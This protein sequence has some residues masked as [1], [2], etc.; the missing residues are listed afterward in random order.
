MINASGNHYLTA[1]L[2]YAKN[3]RSAFLEHLKDFTAIPSVSTDP[4]ARSD[5]QQAAEW[6]AN[7]LRE[8]GV[9][10]VQVM[11]T[12]GHPIVYAEMLTAGS[13]APTVLIYGHYDVQPAEPLEL[14]ISPAFEATVRDE[15][16]FGRGVTDM[17]GQI[18]STIHAVE[19]ILKT[20]ALPVNI[21]F[22]IEGEEEIGSPSLPGFLKEH[23]ELLACDLAL[24]P[25]TG[26]LA[27]DLPTITYA[28]RGLAYFEIRL[29]GPDHDLHS[30]VFGGV[31]HNPGQALCELIA[32]MHDA[33][34]RITLSGFYD[35]V[36][37]LSAEEREELSRIP[38]NDSHFLDETGAPAL[39]GE[40]GYTP[41]E[42]IGARPTLEVNG[43]LSG[44]TGE[45]SKTVLPAWAMAKISMRLVPE[46][47][48]EEVHQQLLA[49]LQANVPPTIRWEV[50][51]MSGGPASLSRRDSTGVLALAKAMESVWGKRPLFKREGGSVPVVNYFRD[52]LG[53]ESVNTGFA[54]PGDNMHSPNEKMHLP[55]WYNAIDTY[56]H[57]L[58]NLVEA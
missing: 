34:G 19:A 41:I 18:M 25:D 16:I 21:K 36:L 52:Y 39:W 40:S 14:W 28:L 54:M 45:G 44:F 55:T 5:V 24:N 48:H 4:K 58:Y 49:Y 33:Q 12:A 17:K 3:N 47:N 42:R 23:A 32:G 13:E 31:V 35:R 56:V 6:V 46:Q 7:Y 22:I 37:P 20:G 8:L 2:T 53:V 57:F 43:L 51:K 15:H 50:K 27:P 11:Q 1:A 9:P 30:G 26:T 38:L 10:R 29:H